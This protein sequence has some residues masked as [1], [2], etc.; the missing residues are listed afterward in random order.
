[1][2]LATLVNLADVE[3]AARRRLPRL[4]WDV[5]AGGAGNEETLRRNREAFS[6]IALRPRSVVDV[7][8]R[9]LSTTVFGQRIALPI[10]LAPTGFNRMAHRDAEV[11]AARAANGAGTVFTLGTI[12]T[13]TPEQVAAAAPGPM[14]FQLYVRPTRDETETLIAR[15]ARSGFSGLVVTV[16]T[17]ITG[18]RERD[19]R[20][21]MTVPL[22]ITPRLIAQAAMRPRW[23]F[24][25]VRGGSGRGTQ[26]YGDV[27]RTVRTVSALIK[28][29][30]RQVTEADLRWIRGQW[31]GPLLVK[32]ILRGDDC[33]RLLATGIDGIVVSNHGGRQLDSVPATIQ[34]LPEVVDAV[35][36]RAQVF[37]DGGFRRGVDVAKALALGARAVLIGRPYVYGLAI[38]GE[39]GVARVIEILGEEF[40]HTLALLGCTSPSDLDRSFVALERILVP[41][42][43]IAKR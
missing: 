28:S 16:D 2:N 14:W 30:A 43:E 7:Q 23:A 13:F 21:G 11:A 37:V 18:I 15:A 19:I 9:D 8:K 1:V 32:G 3:T 42:T 10:M 20:N 31:K 5:I 34:A 6:A 29:S 35:G 12:T 22:R 26:G 17:A 27:F 40:N 36:G 4:V 33:D 39:A 38:G 25:F 24:D 41:A